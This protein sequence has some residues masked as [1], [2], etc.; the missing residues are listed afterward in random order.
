RHSRQA[1]VGR[2]VGHVGPG[3]GA[4]RARGAL[5][6]KRLL[7]LLPLAGGCTDWDQQ[8]ANKL[9]ALDAGEMMPDASRPDSGAPDSGTPDAGCPSGQWCLVQKWSGGVDHVRSVIPD[10]HG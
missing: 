5:P 6:L 10:E 1:L 3:H 4:L 7:L 8:L 9:A 2:A